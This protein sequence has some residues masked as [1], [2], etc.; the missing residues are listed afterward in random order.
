MS[1]EIINSADVNEVPEEE[2]F[3]QRKD[4]LERLRSEEGYDP[5]VNDHWDR[6]HSLG[7]ALGEFDRLAPEES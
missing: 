5:Y 6:T 7:E 3:R 4:K 1:D 2:I